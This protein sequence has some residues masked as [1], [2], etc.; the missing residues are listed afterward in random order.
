MFADITAE[1]SRRG[2]LQDKGYQMHVLRALASDGQQRD[3]REVAALESELQKIHDAEEMHHLLSP[4]R[5]FV[6]ILASN[7]R[8]TG[9]EKADFERSAAQCLAKAIEADF[10]KPQEELRREIEKRALPAL[11]SLFTRISNT[12]E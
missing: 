2:W 1:A 9:F 6:M 8:D 4:L 11:T 3:E 7:A 12:Y 10:M 5:Q